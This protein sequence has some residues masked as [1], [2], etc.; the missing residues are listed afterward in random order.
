MNYIELED[1]STLKAWYEEFN[2]PSNEERYALPGCPY[3]YYQIVRELL[4]R[5]H[6]EGIMEDLGQ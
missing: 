2:R 3:G 1:I 6:I 5:E 4:R